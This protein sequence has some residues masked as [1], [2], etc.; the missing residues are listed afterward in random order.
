ML[1]LDQQFHTGFVVPDLLEAMDGFAATFEGAWTPVEEVALQ[2]TGPD[3][4]LRTTLRVAFS[5]EGP[6]R[7][8]L[9]EA[10][11]GTIWQVPTL[12]DRGDTP[13]HHVGFWAEDLAVESDRLAALGAPLLYTVD[14]GSG[15]VS[16]FAYHRLSSGLVV[17]L[18]DARA[19]RA[20]ERWFAGGP[21]PGGGERR[22]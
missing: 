17:E 3:G 22:T 19:R 10:V 2:L 18:V 13:V 14:D 9:I 7:F 20:F 21:F 5:R 8:E 15:D 11:E 16:F 4:T 1:R 6:Q 12:A